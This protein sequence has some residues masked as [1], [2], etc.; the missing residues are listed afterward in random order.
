MS[1]CSDDSWCS[2]R[3]TVRE[4]DSQ[5]WSHR[6]FFADIKP[7]DGK[8]FSVARLFR[9][10]FRD[11]DTDH[12]SIASMMA[13][14]FVEWIPNNMKASRCWIPT[15]MLLPLEQRRSVNDCTE[16]VSGT[17]VANTTSMKQINKRI[18]A[19]VS[20]KTRTKMFFCSVSSP[21][22]TNE[23]LFFIGTKPKE[24]MKVN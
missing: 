17:L 10:P 14:D 15:K 16:E 19:Q 20:L 6:N 11:F 1:F 4:I 24:W 22:C 3:Y 2:V 7:E 21:K 13:E 5:M 8:Y 18:G 23:G 9:G 12:Y